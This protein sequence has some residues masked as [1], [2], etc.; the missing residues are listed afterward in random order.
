RSRISSPCRR[1]GIARRLYPRHAH[2]WFRWTLGIDYAD[3]HGTRPGRLRARGADRGEMDQ[4]A[5]RLVHDGRRSGVNYVV[6]G[7]SSFDL[8]LVAVSLT[9]SLRSKD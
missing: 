6:L 4:R 2:D 8:G 7:P 3:S 9:K 5:P 1:G